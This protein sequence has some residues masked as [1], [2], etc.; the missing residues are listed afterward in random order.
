MAEQSTQSQAAGS[1]SAVLA[2]AV[3]IG[4]GALAGMLLAP[5]SGMETRRQMKE[6]MHDARSKAMEKMQQKKDM[7]MDKAE[8]AKDKARE[9][10]DESLNRLDSA[11]APR[12]GNAAM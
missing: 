7:V 9:K 12:R 11:T 8:T 10:V 1:F 5:R 4:A 2:F 3:G 6:K